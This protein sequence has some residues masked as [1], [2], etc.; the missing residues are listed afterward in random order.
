MGKV[1]TDNLV[2]IITQIQTGFK[3]IWI[4]IIFRDAPHLDLP[5]GVA[6]EIGKDTKIKHLVIQIHYADVSSFKRS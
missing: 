1:L 5:E 4:F 2:I 6:F 3:C